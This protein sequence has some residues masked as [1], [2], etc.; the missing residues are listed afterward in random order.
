MPRLL[1]LLS[2]VL[3]LLALGVIVLGA[4]VRLSDAGLGCPD[5]PG[6]Y[7]HLGVPS[8]QPDIHLQDPDWHSRPLEAGKAWREMVHRYLASTLGLGIVVLAAG[9]LNAE[10]RRAV[11]LSRV[12]F[13]LVPLVVFQGLLGMWTVTLLLKP[14]VVSGHLLGGL[15][16]LALLWWNL[17]CV[18]GLRPVGRAGM[19]GTLARVAT[20]VL[21][22]QIF[23][24][25]WTS[26]NYAALACT[27][28]PTCQ[29]RWLP[30]TDFREAFVLWRGLGVNYEFGVLETPARTAVHFTHRLGA[31]VTSLVVLLTVAAAFTRAE[32]RLR[33]IASCILAAVLLQ[34]GLGITNVVGGLPLPVAVA[35]NGVAALL[36]LSCL[37]LV[38][39]TRRT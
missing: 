12:V 10:R 15:S 7:G 20:C 36:L 18:R 11:G 26:A 17:L 3:P 23:L 13:L 22:L 30:D 31:L 38:F 25:G 14:L 9:A 2:H 35:H 21:V 16:T 29:G 19:V 34:V 32:P 1:R 37:T 28:F 5:W 27:D 8:D 39:A 6:C 24:G 4:Y 33:Q